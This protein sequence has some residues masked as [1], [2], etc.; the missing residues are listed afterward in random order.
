[1]SHLL[2][3]MARSQTRSYSMA[4]IL[5]GSTHTKYIIWRGILFTAVD[6]IFTLF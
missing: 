5:L 1:M 3:Q 2:R 6:L 4:V